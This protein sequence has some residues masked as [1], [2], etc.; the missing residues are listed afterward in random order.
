MKIN[1][2]GIIVVAAILL[3]SILFVINLSN[4]EYGSYTIPIES[5]K[6]KVQDNSNYSHW[7]E[8]DCTSDISTMAE[9]AIKCQESNK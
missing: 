1:H 2:G 5:Q 6:C 3:I 8:Y 9:E 4:S 7:C